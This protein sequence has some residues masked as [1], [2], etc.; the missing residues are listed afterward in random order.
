MLA[1]AS[2]SNARFRVFLA[3]VA[4]AATVPE[5]VHCIY[6]GN[7]GTLLILPL[8]ELFSGRAFGA[9]AFPVDTI[10]ATGT[11]VSAPAT[12]GAIVLDTSA[13]EIAE[14][15]LTEDFSLVW[16]L[17]V[18]VSADERGVITQATA[19]AAV[20]AIILQVEASV[21]T[22]KAPLI[23]LLCITRRKPFLLALAL[24]L[25]TDQKE[26]APVAA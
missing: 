9:S 13:G 19:D 23:T 26:T 12:V 10:L 4:A 25:A 6:A 15:V 20:V 2:T 14:F 3:F 5:I 24:A 22:E 18:A 11:H 21:F 17:A 1:Y 16:T 8:T 7:S